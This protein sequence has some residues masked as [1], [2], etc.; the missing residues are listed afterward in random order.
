MYGVDLVGVG[1]VKNNPTATGGPGGAKPPW[2]MA[3]KFDELAGQVWGKMSTI[4][5]TI[6]GESTG[7]LTRQTL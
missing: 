5:S 4:Q 1:I 3:S 7:Q 6:D 2:P